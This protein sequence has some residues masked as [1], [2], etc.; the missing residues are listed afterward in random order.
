[1]KLSVGYQDEW[2]GYTYSEEFIQ[3]K[4]DYVLVTL[5]HAGGTSLIYKNWDARVNCKVLNI[6]Y[7]GHWTRKN[8][9]FPDTFLDLEI[10]IYNYL[11]SKLDENNRILLFGH[12][13]GAIFAWHIASKLI[14]NHFCVEG[15]F[16]SGSDS[17]F[18][19]PKLNMDIIH[20][21]EV[22]ELAGYDV[23]ISKDVV[24][25]TA[26]PILVKQNLSA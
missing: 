2:I 20:D 3:M 8:E 13:M 10:D 9:P 21:D 25:K 6:D 11:L 17:P 12:S 24:L 1:M 16:L 4:N 7:P 14:D 26:K 15:L 18:C 22:L 23:I 19:F 5:P